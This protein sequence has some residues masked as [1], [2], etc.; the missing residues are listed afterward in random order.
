MP[1]LA[2][3]NEYLCILSLTTGISRQ[4]R[5]VSYNIRQ[6]DELQHPSDETR[7]VSKSKSGQKYTDINTKWTDFKRNQV[8]LHFP[9]H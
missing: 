7:L 3:D 5:S 8:Y 4:G 6:G 9:S 1:S 2:S